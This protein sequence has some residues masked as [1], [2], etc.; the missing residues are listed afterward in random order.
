MEPGRTCTDETGNIGYALVF[1]QDG[2]QTIDHFLGAF[3]GRTGRQVHFNGELVSFHFGE[4]LLVGKLKK[5]YRTN[6]RTNS[7]GNDQP[8]MPEGRVKRFI[9]PSLQKIKEGLFIRFF[10]VSQS[11]FYEYKIQVRYQ[12]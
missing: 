10:G 5:E 3:Q 8:G 12:E 6:N 11:F 4:Q 7:D 2:F 1:Q 9:E